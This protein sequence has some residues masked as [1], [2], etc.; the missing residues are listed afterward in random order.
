MSPG[1]P[2]FSTL[3]LSLLALPVVYAQTPR[4]TNADESAVR[5][6]VQQMQDGW[7]AGDG[8]AFAAPFAADA[9]YV[10]VNG[11]KIKGR[12]EIE[13]SHQRIFNT[14]YK[15]SHNEGTVKSLRFLRSDLALMHVEWHLRYYAEGQPLDRKALGTLVVAKAKGQ[16][17]IAAFQNT[18]IN[19]EG[20]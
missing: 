7:N 3:I 20:R 8:K 13:Q 14:V 5:R 6:I 11:M 15:G 4:T 2:I 17:S 9:D 1:L 19:T 10:I 12:D 16:W 18:Y